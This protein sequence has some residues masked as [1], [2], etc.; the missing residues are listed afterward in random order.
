MLLFGFYKV[1]N[2]IYKNEKK[3]FITEL[4]INLGLITREEQF[5]LDYSKDEWTFVKVLTRAIT[6][7][8]VI[9]ILIA[10]I[11]A[12]T[13]GYKKT[14]FAVP[15]CLAYLYADIKILRRKNRS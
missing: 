6:Y 1:L 7:P 11:W 5:E 13:M 2:R 4:K 12:T 9:G 14:I 8:F 3:Y 15:I 10:S